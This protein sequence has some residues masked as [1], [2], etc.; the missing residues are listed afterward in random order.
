MKGTDLLL[1]AK[2]KCDKTKMYF[3]FMESQIGEK[4][5]SSVEGTHG[6]QES[7]DS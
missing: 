4:M 1:T 2:K 3:P 7:S 5:S 6:E